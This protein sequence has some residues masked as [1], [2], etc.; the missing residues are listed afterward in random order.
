MLTGIRKF[1]FL[2]RPSKSDLGGWVLRG[3]V[4]F[5][6]IVTGAEKF[7]NGVGAPWVG[8]FREIGL[9]DWFRYFTGIVEIIAGLLYFLPWTCPIGAVLLACTML[10]AMT[11]H[12]FVRHSAAASLY[13]AFV[14]FAVIAIAIRQPDDPS[15]VGRRMFSRRS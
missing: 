5:F 6:F 8:I 9:G 3:G 10:G 2:R 15:E 12:I 13:P 1:G 7:R 4:A 14:L 11:V